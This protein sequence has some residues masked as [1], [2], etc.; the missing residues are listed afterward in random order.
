M[1]SGPESVEDYYARIADSVDDDGRLPVAL[2]EA[3]GWFIYPT[4]LT[5][6]G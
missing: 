2:D 1:T 4:R 3:P 6:C 5:R